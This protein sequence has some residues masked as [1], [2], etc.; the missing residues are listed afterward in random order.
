MRFIIQDRENN[1]D[2]NFT[3]IYRHEEY[4]FDVEESIEGHDFTS[5]MVNDLQ[6]EI[7]DEENHLCMGIMS[8]YRIC[9]NKRI[10]TRIQ[11]MQ[12]CCNIR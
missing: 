6:L 8:T 4:S 9:K 3:I 10:P 5:I 7:N 12:S 1:W 11:I 2:F